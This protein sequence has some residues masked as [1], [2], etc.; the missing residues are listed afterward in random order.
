LNDKLTAEFLADYYENHRRQ[1]DGT[2]IEVAHLLIKLEPNQDAEIV[3]AT[4]DRLA[5]IREQIASGSLTWDA[6]VQEHSQAA[7]RTDKGMIGWIRLTEPMPMEFARAAFKLSPGEVSPPVHTDFGVHLIKCL[8]IKPG[9]K[10]WRDAE[11]EI[12]DHA[13]DFLFHEISQNHAAK[14]VVKYSD[15]F[16]HFDA[17]GNLAGIE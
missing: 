14:V 10:G 11:P 9:K 6:A 13:T 2:E 4:V 3:A 8:D 12:R 5:R 17:N 16:P 7:S 1:F 15:D